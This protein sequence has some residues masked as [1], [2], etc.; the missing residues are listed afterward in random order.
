MEW[1]P[2][3][4]FMCLLRAGWIANLYVNWA[5]LLVDSYNC[6]CAIHYFS[7]IYSLLHFL[8]WMWRAKL[9]A[10]AWSIQRSDWSTSELFICWIGRFLSVC[11]EGSQIVSCVGAY[12][13]WDQ[14]NMLKLFTYSALS[15]LCCFL[16]LSDLSLS[17]HFSQ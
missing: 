1:L 11:I 6:T 17:D 5:I 16:L 12:L 7:L 9:A 8:V 3:S 15:P 13:P 4:L 14:W 10:N 2:P